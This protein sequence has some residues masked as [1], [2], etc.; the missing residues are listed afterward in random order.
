MERRGC[1][2]RKVG[3]LYLVGDGFPAECLK[4]PAELTV[5]P[6]C[7]HGIKFF[8]GYK[9]V[10]AKRVFGG[11]CVDTGL[12][13]ERPEYCVDRECPFEMEKVGL[14]W[15]GKRF[16]S[17][18]SFIE[19]A[20][21]MGI[22][23]RI[24]AIPKDFELGKTWVLLAHLEAVTKDFWVDAEPGES[25]PLDPD[26][27]RTENGKTQIL[28][29]EKVGGVFYVFKPSKIELTV[30]QK[31]LD[32]M[33]EEERESNARRGITYYI[34]PEGDEKHMGSVYDFDDEVDEEE[35]GGEDE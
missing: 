11:D 18:K 25:L 24:S 31:M 12:T 20:W 4:L 17:P 28:Q 13:K 22:S 9:S 21:D 35:E 8:R 2:Y 23:K 3:G 7:S 30:T 1:G 14:M 32:E 16:Y 19:E 6:C 33:T 26:R 34:V 27:V 15:V 5:C 10:N 29:K